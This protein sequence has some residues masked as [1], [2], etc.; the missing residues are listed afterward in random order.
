M[1]LS[2]IGRRLE[3]YK[4]THNTLSNEQGQAVKTANVVYRDTNMDVVHVTAF[5]GIL[6]QFYNAHMIWE[7]TYRNGGVVR[8]L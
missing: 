7:Q 1:S 8:L 3:G 5:N 4:R 6:T 2:W